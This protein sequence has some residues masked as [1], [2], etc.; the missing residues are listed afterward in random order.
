VR[1]TDPHA[2]RLR[3]LQTPMQTRPQTVVQTTQTMRQT[4]CTQTP[5]HPQ[6]V[7]TPFAR[8]FCPAANT[9][10]LT[11]RSRSQP[12]IGRSSPSQGR[13]T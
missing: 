7:C 3:G 6:A 1:L 10:A 5:L 13:T 4:T 8:A 11:L 2:D 9:A 12:P